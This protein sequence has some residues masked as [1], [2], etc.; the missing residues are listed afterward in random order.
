MVLHHCVGARS[1]RVLWALE[2][3]GVPYDLRVLPFPPRVACAEFLSENP[4]GTVPLFI[5]GGVRMTESSAICTYLGTL[6]PS[7]P[8]AVT[9]DHEDYPRYLNDLF[10]GEATLT[11]P[12]T[13]ALRY[14]RF[15]P[16]D[17][18][19]P[20]VVADYSRWFLSRLHT[21][22][23]RLA[24]SEYLCARRFTMADISV[25]YALALAQHLDLSA[26]FRP[27]VLEYWQ[28][29]QTLPSYR[30]ALAAERG[31]AIRQGVDS[32]PAPRADVSHWTRHPVEE[33]PGRTAA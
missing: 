31:A 9:P 25:G 3:L 17:R 30:R 13:I 5:Q 27:S 4:L 19:V 28:R 32:N 2:E 24:R 20:Q 29:L 22:A 15:E 21:L 33:V 8:V 26:R 1:F 14:S 10:F 23:P 6:Y 16:A 11:F 12:Q 18:L 7:H